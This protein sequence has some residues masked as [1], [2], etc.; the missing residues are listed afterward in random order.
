MR[1]SD[2][3]KGAWEGWSDAERQLRDHV[4]NDDPREFTRWEIIRGTM[5]MHK[6]LSVVDEYK[7][8]KGLPEWKSRW[9][10]AVQESADGSAAA[11][12]YVSASRAETSSITRITCCRSR[13]HALQAERVQDNF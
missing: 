5:F 3:G 2:H 10:P 4:L 9:E 11:L 6:G 13:T 7:T 8:L 12:L 1:Q